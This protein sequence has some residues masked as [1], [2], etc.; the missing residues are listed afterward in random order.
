MSNDNLPAE[1]AG[2]VAD[3]PRSSAELVDDIADL[4]E[5]PAEDLPEDD[6]AQAKAGETDEGDEPEVEI[7]PEDVENAESADDEDG[8]EPEIKGGRF[9]PDSAKVTLED[10]SVITVAELKRNNLFQRDYTKKT[11]D[12]AAERE[13]INA[14]KSEVDQQAQSLAQLAERLTEFSKAYLPQ[15]PEPFT[16]NSD[17]DPLGYMRYMKARDAY[18]T[19]VRS[20]NGIVEGR[21]QLTAKEQHEREEQATKALSDELQLL[22]TKDRFFADNDR[23]KAFF[24]EA[25]EKGAGYWDL[26]PDD[27]RGL[28]SHKAIRILRDAMNYRKALEKAANTQKQVQAKPVMV[29]GGK[30]ADPRTKVSSEKV[31]RSERLRRDGS[32]QNG[33]AALMDLDL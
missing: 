2:P 8:S 13:Q 26:T 16:G 6:Q 19:A 30:R 14:R 12:L 27:V 7:D 9:A 18:D 28:R 4:L 29:K 20:F 25:A 33:V 23:A 3:A 31:A 1:N 5:D 10:G 21:T 22:R 17:D 15:P 24:A 32:F 11:T